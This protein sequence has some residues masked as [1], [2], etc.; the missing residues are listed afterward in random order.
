MRGGFKCVGIIT[1][2]VLFFCMTVNA[3]A[4]EQTERFGGWNVTVT[5][6]AW[7]AGVNGDSAVEGRESST[8]DDFPDIFAELD[9][10]GMLNVEA[11]KIR[12]T[13]FAEAAYLD[14][15]ADAH[16][17]SIDTDLGVET[18][19]IELGGMYRL[20]NRPV[21]RRVGSSLFAELLAGVRYMY[22][23]GDIDFEDT[24]DLKDSKHWID[25]IVGGRVIVDLA[26]SSVVLCRIDFG[27]FGLSDESDFTWNFLAEWG[28]DVSDS[29]RIRLGYRAMGVDYETG[30]GPDDLKFD[31]TISGPFAGAGFRF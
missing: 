17:G 5:P 4:F 14:L 26:G 19:F 28:Y 13:L 10:N 18:A 30:S 7:F 24:S 12:W 6:Y 3:L 2:V 23:E 15:T 8:D 22:M 29:L 1:F 16:V 25:P 9:L 31:L 27:G 21:G 11:R 20:V